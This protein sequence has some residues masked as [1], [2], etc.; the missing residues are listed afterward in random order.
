M[1]FKDAKLWTPY[2]L[3][4]PAKTTK[5]LY[6]V[7]SVDSEHVHYVKIV[8]HKRKMLWR[9]VPPTYDFKYTELPNPGEVIP[10]LFEF[11]MVDYL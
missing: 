11:E 4:T 8:V 7:T 2:T 3:K 1:Q 9:K 10:C 5:W 6:F